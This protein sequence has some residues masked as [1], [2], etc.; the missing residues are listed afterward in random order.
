MKAQDMPWAF[1]MY[2]LF[3]NIV[4]SVTNSSDDICLKYPNKQL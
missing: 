3:P 2:M 1:I 4:I